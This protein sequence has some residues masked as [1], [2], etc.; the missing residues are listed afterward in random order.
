MRIAKLGPLV[1]SALVCLS[2]CP[3]RYPVQA[4][5]YV[6]NQ[7]N[8]LN[9]IDSDAPTTAQSASVG[10]TL[11]G[12]VITRDGLHVAT[13]EDSEQSELQVYLPDD[14]AVGDTISG[15]VVRPE[16]SA[17]EPVT[18]GDELSGVVVEIETPETTYSAT[19]GEAFQINIP[20]LLIDDFVYVVVKDLVGD[21]LIRVE[22]PVHS[23]PYPVRDSARTTA[24]D[25]NLPETGEVGQPTTIT[26]PFDGDWQTT[27]V[28]V[29]GQETTTLAESPRKSI[30]QSPQT[31]AGPTELVLQEDSVIARGDYVNQGPAV[32][33][34][35][36]PQSS[37]TIV[38]QRSLN[39]NPGCAIILDYFLLEL[40]SFVEGGWQPPEPPQ[41]GTYRTRLHYLVSRNGTVQEATIV[42]P[43][44]YLP[45]DESAFSHVNSLSGSLPEFPDCYTGTHVFVDHGFTLRVSTIG[46]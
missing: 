18:S 21:E 43:S 34:D 1:C 27:S 44:G 46:F 25:Y 8:S 6:G 12:R 16:I 31:V 23:T 19:P 32:A 35:E 29:G 38:D 9:L 5:G 4:S 2:F 22:I 3:G 41:D 37:S 11:S 13:F 40:E 45:I 26:G 30:F 28:T 10:D 15:R 20:D 14:M 36:D 33:I 17:T 42:Q 24:S 7:S 39:L